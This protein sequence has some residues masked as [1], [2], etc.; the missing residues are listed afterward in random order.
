[1]LGAI[2]RVVA[3]MSVGQMLL[4]LSGRILRGRTAPITLWVLAASGCAS[5]SC[6]SDLFLSE[7]ARQARDVVEIGR[8]A[9]VDLVVTDCHSARNR[10]GDLGSFSCLTKLDNTQKQR[11]IEG[12]GMKVPTIGRVGTATDHYTCET[13]VDLPYEKRRPDLAHG[14][15]ASDDP[16]KA[17]VELHVW[18]DGLA[19]IEL[20]SISRWPIRDQ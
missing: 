10:A 8:R 2:R 6:V 5:R 20:G 11:M 12:L 3:G 13:R 17:N 16:A 15:W 19:C 7:D 1:M 9:G 14:V 18:P 4:G